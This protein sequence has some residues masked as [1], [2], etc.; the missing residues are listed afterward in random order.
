M[1]PV[2]FNLVAAAATGVLAMMPQAVAAEPVLVEGRSQATRVVVVSR[3]ELSN[4]ART[5]AVQLRLSRA[6]KAVCHEQYRNE[7]VYL[8]ARACYS[9]SLGDAM[10]RFGQ[11]RT[12]SAER[13]PGADGVSVTVVAR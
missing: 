12:L 11:L 4:P 2:K 9:G 1:F 13:H 3:A 8:F 10:E 6:A 7:S 5:G